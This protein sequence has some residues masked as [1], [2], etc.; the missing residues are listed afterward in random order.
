MSSG[1]TKISFIIPAHNEQDFIGPC[2]DSILKEID[3][4]RCESEILVINNASTDNTR[5]T[6]LLFPGVNVIDELRKGAVYARQTGFLLA[7]GDYVVSVD[8]DSILPKN[9]IKTA[10]QEF[11]KEPNLVAVSGPLEYHDASS[12][13]NRATK[14]FYVLGFGTYFVNR[15]ILRTG[16]I[17]QGGAFM[18]KRS[19]LEK[20]GFGYSSNFEFWG[21]DID[22][23]RRLCEVGD[24]KFTNKLK[25]TTSARRIVAEGAITMG[26]RYSINALS[27][28]FLKKPYSTEYKDIR[29]KPTTPARSS[30]WKTNRSKYLAVMILIMLFFAGVAMVSASNQDVRSQAKEISAKIVGLYHK[31]G[32]N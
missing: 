19:A 27:A 30:F 2:L 23:A 31:V 12:R 29:Q 24:V 28:T 7:V 16:S 6:A 21:D 18:V 13:L 5:S 8:A 10:L 3:H 4:S 22:L 11:S 20:I 32:Q 15:F 9:W 25:F 14:W 1:N 17:L 26:T